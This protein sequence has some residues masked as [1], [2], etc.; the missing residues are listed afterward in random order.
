MATM[1]W[2]AHN[3]STELS[4]QAEIARPVELIQS[5]IP[6]GIPQGEL[7]QSGLGPEELGQASTD[8]LVDMETA[9]YYFKIEDFIVKKNK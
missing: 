9:F 8:D 6:S 4:Q 2:G 5:Y 7:E 1:R 3:S